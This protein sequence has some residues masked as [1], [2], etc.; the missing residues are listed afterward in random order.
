[1]SLPLERPPRADRN[2]DNKVDTGRLHARRFWRRPW[3]ALIV[4][5]GAEPDEGDG[6][7]ESEQI[8]QL[9]AAYHA[10]DVPRPVRRKEPLALVMGCYQVGTIV[11]ARHGAGRTG[12]PRWSRW[13]YE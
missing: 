12:V 1:M 7:R 11:D 8:Q 4:E 10:A 6:S 3:L 13:V 2:P 9:R 5:M